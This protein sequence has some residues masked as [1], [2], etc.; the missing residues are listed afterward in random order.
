MARRTIRHLEID[1]SS[2]FKDQQFDSTPVYLLFRI[3][4]TQSY[5]SPSTFSAISR[6]CCGDKIAYSFF[7]DIQ[8]DQLIIEPSERPPASL[9]AV[10]F[11]VHARPV[12]SLSIPALAP[13]RTR[14]GSYVIA[15]RP[16]HLSPRS[17]HPLV[18]ACFQS[19]R[20]FQ[21]HQYH[22]APFFLD[23]CSYRSL[24]KQRNCCLSRLMASQKWQLQG[25]HL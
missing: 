3:F 17:S 11:M 2:F 18:L 25:V 16:M 6:D 22:I 4:D 13:I 9:N 20:W 15:C 1:M 23:R 19:H 8:H 24:Q 14:A 7:F 5:S 10:F 21:I 12:V